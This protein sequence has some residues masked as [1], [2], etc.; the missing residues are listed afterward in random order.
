MHPLSELTQPTT[1]CT[2]LSLPSKL[3]PTLSFLPFPSPASTCT[4]TS[5]FMPF[6]P[7][8]P[9]SSFPPLSSPIVPS[10]SVPLPPPFASFFLTL[11]SRSPHSPLPPHSFSLQPV[12]FADPA[13]MHARI[14]THFRL[15][16]LFLLSS[17][18]P[19]TLWSLFSRIAAP[20]NLGPLR[21]GILLFFAAHL[22]PHAPSTRQLL[23]YIR[24]EGGSEGGGAAAG[25]GKGGKEEKVLEERLRLAKKAIANIAGTPY[26]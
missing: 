11:S 24:S 12:D 23:Q 18:P 7:L 17:F 19:A 2:S 22:S 14:A 8:P 21:D 3:R 9:P 26:K 15:F 4:S 10:L 5:S 20:T 25:V 1:H 6:P 16:F 13:A